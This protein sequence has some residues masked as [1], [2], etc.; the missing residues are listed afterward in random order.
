MPGNDRVVLA[1]RDT[2]PG[3]V[4]REFVKGIKPLIHVF[5]ILHTEAISTAYVSYYTARL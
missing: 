2:P 4:I 5:R 1:G 3:F